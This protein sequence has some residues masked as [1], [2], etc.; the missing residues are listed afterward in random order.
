M[1]TLM[2]QRLYKDKGIEDLVGR[3]VE[4]QTICYKQDKTL[5]AVRSK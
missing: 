3:S 5:T 4:Q 2:L 1:A